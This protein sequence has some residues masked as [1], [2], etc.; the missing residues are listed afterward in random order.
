[1][2]NKH[3]I[4]YCFIATTQ[5]RTNNSRTAGLQF[6]DFPGLSRICTNP[7]IY[8]GEIKIWITAVALPS[9]SPPDSDGDATTV[10]SDVPHHTSA[11]AVLG[12]FIW[13]GQS[14]GQAN[15]G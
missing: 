5:T 9:D 7:V 13:V 10:D 11:G 12:I 14:E 2:F 15:F 8:S 4:A 6:P 1:M 3:V